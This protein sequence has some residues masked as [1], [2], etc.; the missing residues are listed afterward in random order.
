MRKYIL[1]WACVLVGLVAGVLLISAGVHGK[2]QDAFLERIAQG[3]K[4]LAAGSA[5]EAVI[6]YEAARALPGTDASMVSAKLCAAY[7]VLAEGYYRD[8]AELSDQVV[9]S[10]IYDLEKAEVLASVQARPAVKANYDAASHHLDEAMQEAQK[11]ER[12]PDEAK[13]WWKGQYLLGNVYFRTLVM[14]NKTPHD[15]R[16]TKVKRLFRE[17]IQSYKNALASRP[18]PMTQADK[19]WDT[20][21]KQNL[22]QVMGMESNFEA[23]VLA[24]ESEIE[25]MSGAGETG[26]EQQYTPVKLLSPGKKDT[27]QKGDRVGVGGTAGEK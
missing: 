25:N 20:Y 18:S 17:C 7:N 22:E 9:P 15:P 14:V 27:Q 3:D 10:V 2:R 1:L 26:D 5:S 11:V 8:W 16:G 19:V 23:S 6:H 21:I 13:L 24:Q 12:Y 4:A